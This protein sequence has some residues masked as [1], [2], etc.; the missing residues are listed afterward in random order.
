MTMMETCEEEK[1]RRYRTGGLLDM[2]EYMAD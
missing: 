1:L 2:L